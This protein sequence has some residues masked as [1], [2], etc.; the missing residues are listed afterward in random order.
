MIELNIKL[1]L[2]RY[3]E[4]N[5]DAK[6]KAFDD[7]EHFLRMYPAQSEDNDGNMIDD[8]MDTWTH[9][10]IKGYVEECIRINEYFY[11]K[12]GTMANCTT[13]TGDHHK[14]GITELKYN[15]E[16]YIIKDGA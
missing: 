13:Y 14:S 5:D 11:F 7:H 9:E 8:D 12:D 6:V 4:L 1:Q 2:F 16:I 3:D 10:E 15:G